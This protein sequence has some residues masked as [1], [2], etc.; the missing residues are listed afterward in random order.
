M[1]PLPPRTVTWLL[2]AACFALPTIPS[3]AADVPDSVL[4]EIRPEALRADMRFLADDL[5]EGRGSGTRGYGLGAAFVRAQF[6]SMGLAPAGDHGTYYQSVPL[7]AMNIDESASSLVLTRG[8]TVERMAIQRDFILTADPLRSDVQIEA[9]VVFVGFGITAPEQHYDDYNHID[10]RG[11]I[12]AVVFGAPDF[13]TAVKAHYTAS[14]VKRQ[15]A[16]AHG[17]IGFLVVYDPRY[18][19][20]YPFAKRAQ[21]T[22]QRQLRYVAPDGSANDYEPQLKAVATLSMAAAD[23]LFAGSKFDSNAVFASSGK[24]QMTSFELPVSLAVHTVSHSKDLPGI[25]VVAKL[26]GSDAILKSQ[27]VLYTAHLDHLGLNPALQGDQ[28][29]NGALD[30]ASGTAALLEVARAYSRS[31]VKP[32]RSL[33]FAVVTGEEDGLLGSA[34]LASNPPVALGSLIANINMDEDLMLWPLRD[35]IGVGAEHSSLESDLKRATARLG[36]VSSPDPEPD[37]VLF[38]R[39]DQYSFV[40]KGI[41]SMFLMAGFK[42]DDPKIDPGAIYDKWITDTYHHPSDDMQQPGL[43]FDAAALYSKTA[44][45]TGW[46]VADDADTP[47]WNPGD[48]FKKK[49]ASAQ[50]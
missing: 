18:E 2:I 47:R 15:N 3:A 7:R 42:S 9:P 10:A 28:I 12:V 23:R 14:W 13:Q 5:L 27:H 19:A 38:I 45:L 25:N 16:V 41:P 17:A 40:R 4:N 26:S 30:N 11:K 6:E 39:S 34:Y 22:R 8:T 1:S 21:D 48:F 36:L 35:V 37:Q 43:D 31:S 46:Y 50:P 29:F 49:F 32:K 20:L 24:K 44:F 33:L